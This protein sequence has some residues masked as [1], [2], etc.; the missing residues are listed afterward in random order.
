MIM[1]A[2]LPQKRPGK[3]LAA[4]IRQYLLHER[5]M[6]RLLYNGIFCIAHIASTSHQL[7]QMRCQHFGYDWLLMLTH[8]CCQASYVTTASPAHR[9]LQ[10]L[11]CAG[12]E[13]QQSSKRPASARQLQRSA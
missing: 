10:H 13:E 2:D 1:A 9:R 3:K 4:A 5:G 12:S 7:M 6:Y 11:Y 8:T